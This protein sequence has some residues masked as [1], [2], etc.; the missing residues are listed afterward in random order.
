VAIIL[1]LDPGSRISGIGVLAVDRDRIQHVFHGVIN[2]SNEVSFAKRVSKIG[3]EFRK[4][5]EQFK[6]DVVVI[7]QI[8]LGKNVDSAFKLGHARGICMYES[9]IAGSEIH[10]YA[11]RLVKKMVT[12]SGAADKLQVQIALERLLQINIQGAI[13]ASDALALAYHHAIQ[14]EVVRKVNKMNLNNSMG[15]CR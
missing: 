3:I 13:D 11:T 6:P 1:G 9:V 14:M 5:L 7:E 4:I 15:S 8:F 2:S 12:G 10:E